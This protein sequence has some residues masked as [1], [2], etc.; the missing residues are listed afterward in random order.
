MV[1]LATSGRLP[2]GGRER[3]V[4]LEE[5]EDLKVWVHGATLGLGPMGRGEHAGETLIPPGLPWIRFKI[6]T[7]GGDSDRPGGGE[8]TQFDADIEWE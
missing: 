7:S 1:S 6:E 2:R 3:S 5:S 8:G 4:V